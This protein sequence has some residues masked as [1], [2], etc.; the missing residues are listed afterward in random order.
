MNMSIKSVEGNYLRCC[1][2]GRVTRTTDMWIMRP[3]CNVD[4]IVKHAN[5]FDAGLGVKPGF[6]QAKFKNNFI[7]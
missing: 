6:Q 5:K 2:K 7:P 1:Q 3:V 4:D